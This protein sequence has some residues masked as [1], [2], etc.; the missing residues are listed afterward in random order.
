MDTLQQKLKEFNSHSRDTTNHFK[1]CPPNSANGTTYEIRLCSTHPRLITCTPDS[2]HIH[3]THHGPSTFRQTFSHEQDSLQSLLT[4]LKKHRDDSD[5]L[6]DWELEDWVSAGY[7]C[8]L[9]ETKD[10]PYFPDL[11]FMP[12]DLWCIDEQPSRE[13]RI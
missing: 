13:A 8:K 4:L 5:S 6:L 1:L 7:P 12:E 2:T 3:V 10:Q 11:G 9:H